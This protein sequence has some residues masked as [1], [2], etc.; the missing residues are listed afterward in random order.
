MSLTAR[1]YATALLADCAAAY[2]SS[3]S[4]QDDLGS[5]QR[6][7]TY[8]SREAQLK[9][10]H[11]YFAKSVGLWRELRRL[12]L[13][14]GPVVSIGAGPCLCLLGWFWESA[15]RP[16]Q[17]VVAVDALGWEHVRSLPSHSDLLAEVLGNDFTYLAGRHVPDGPP[18]PQVLDIGPTMAFAPEEIEPGST[19]LMPFLLNHLLGVA[20]PVPDAPEVFDWIRR[21]RMRA[22]EVFIVDMPSDVAQ[23]FWGH[24]AAGFTTL[25][26]PKVQ[27]AAGASEFAS[28]YPDRASWRT[29]RVRQNMLR[30][31]ALL[32]R[33]HEAWEYV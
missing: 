15:G 2:P 19:V 7:E 9:Y 12:S 28:L 22:S 30:Y 29:R 14:S 10:T 5:V 24:A 25:N 6:V 13:G 3:A 8:A 1:R 4:I 18:P 21:V 27:V 11:M 20:A 33:D 23:G 31:T 26:S 16:D 32:S 17:E